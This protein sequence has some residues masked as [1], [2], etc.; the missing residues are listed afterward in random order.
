MAKSSEITEPRCIE[1]S[2][3]HSGGGKVAIRDFG[4]VTSNWGISLSRRYEVP[5]DWTEEQVDEFQVDR[6]DHLHQLIE[7]I[8][9]EE[10][11]TRWE[12]KRWDGD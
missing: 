6:S 7:P 10:F 12:Q 1:V 3:Q 8:D 4:K 9:Q 11:D 5:S 2:V